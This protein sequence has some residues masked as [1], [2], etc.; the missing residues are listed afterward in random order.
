MPDRKNEIR[1]QMAALANE[2]DAGGLPDALAG[3]AA[4][5]ALAADAAVDAEGVSAKEGLAA[6]ARDM[7][8]RLADRLDA[9][10]RALGGAA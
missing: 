4:H 6:I 5:I 8:E 10:P 2:L 7:A 1:R 3:M 9:L